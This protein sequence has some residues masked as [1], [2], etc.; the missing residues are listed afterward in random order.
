MV[1]PGELLE[2]VSCKDA[3]AKG[4]AHYLVPEIL[5]TPAEVARMLW[6]WV[7]GRLPGEY[8]LR[9]LNEYFD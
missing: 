1:K 6:S 5:A 8:E 4:G 9:E 3:S 7:H 2:M